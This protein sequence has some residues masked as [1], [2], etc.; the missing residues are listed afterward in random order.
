MAVADSQ[1][2]LA[3]VK[4]TTDVA[5]DIKGRT[6]LEGENTIPTGFLIQPFPNAGPGV[7]SQAW[8]GENC[9]LVKPA[10]SFSE[11]VRDDVV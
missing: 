11:L 4:V 7:F 1:V 9:M 5:R 6:L 2:P 3:A 10:S 8:R